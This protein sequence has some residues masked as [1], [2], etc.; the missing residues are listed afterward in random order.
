L[1]SVYLSNSLTD[2][3]EIWYGQFPNKNVWHFPFSVILIHNNAQFIQVYLC[4]IHCSF[5]WNIL[6]MFYSCVI[7]LIIH[8]IIIIHYTLVNINYTSPHSKNSQAAFMSCRDWPDSWNWHICSLPR[9]TTWDWNSSGYW[10]QHFIH[11]ISCCSSKDS[12]RKSS[13]KHHY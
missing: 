12:H 6:V 10:H 2:I 5:L 3:V 13:G 8:R 11:S 4:C 1:I 9:T 7:L